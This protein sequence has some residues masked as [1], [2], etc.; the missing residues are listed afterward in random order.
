MRTATVSLLMLALLALA[1]SGWAQE[2]DY[3]I[4]VD[5]P[6]SRLYH[7]EAELP[8]S[9]AATL[10]SL[11]AWTPGYYEI[12]DYARYVRNFGASAG[13]GTA[14]R[15]EKVD[16]DTWRIHSRGVR[17]VRV[18]FDFLAEE[19]T[20]ASSLLRPDF[21]F[22]NGTN[23][24]VYPES[25]HDFPARIRFA[26]PEGWRIA[27]ELVET[28]DPNL[29]WARDYHELVDNP[30]FVGHFTID[31]L[32]ADGVWTRLAI[33][34]ADAVNEQGRDMMLDAL[35]R[36]ADYA[37]DLFGE[38]PY[39]R[40]TTLLYLY[41]G[42]PRYG[43]GLEHANS[44]FDIGAAAI[45][46]NP[47]QVEQTI[48]EFAYGLFA[49][50]YYH[51]WNVKRIRPAEMWPYAYDHE[52][53]TPL[54]WVSEGFTSYYGPLILVRTGLTDEETFWQTMAGAIR[55]VESQPYQ[56]SVE[57][58]SLSTWIDPIPISGGYYYDKGSLIGLLLDLKIREATDNR[59]SLDE[60]MYRLYHDHYARD[61]GFTTEEFLNYVAEYIGRDGLQGFYRDH[62]DGRLPL[63]YG[64]VLALAGMSFEVD[65][66]VE[67]LLGISS[68][69]SEE[70]RVVIQ[71]TVPGSSAIAVGLQAG[72]QLL[73]VGHVEVT[74]EGWAQQFREVY[75][76]ST[77]VPFT[78]EFVRNGERMSGSANIG[79]RTRFE[80]GITPMANA[81]ERQLMVRR[82]VVEGVT[83]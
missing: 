45:F 20:L 75:A 78:V 17:R 25:R 74:G 59:H 29:F 82:G 73:R 80:Y 69:Y 34:P 64:E 37:H 40:Y 60:V 16:K 22:F 50:E 56:E 71:G 21:G 3:L 9:G 55:D 61:R 53:Y 62:I 4:R 58:V 24:F 72:D 83:R 26:L 36:I 77:G 35:Q 28:T 51:A 79:T 19:M 33:Y 52:Q 43:G 48:R 81:S 67:P 32:Q 41:D 76:D 6:N 39:Q 12:A 5:D 7:V 38:P 8:A 42:E 65:T 14:L 27:T 54:L 47:D 2:V 23:L 15:W 30:T 13:D 57:D 68:R 49:H 46:A 31:S 44:H 10:V 63:P 11:P 18:S 66:I 70:G 1:A